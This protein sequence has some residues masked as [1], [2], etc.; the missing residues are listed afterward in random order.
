MPIEL[1]NVYLGIPNYFM[2][3][4]FCIKGV[5]V[6]R[7]YVVTSTKVLLEPRGEAVLGLIYLAPYATLSNTGDSE[8]T[9]ET[10]PE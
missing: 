4:L 2:L 5:L 10:S 1:M 7:G 8:I 6:R 9:L 3:I